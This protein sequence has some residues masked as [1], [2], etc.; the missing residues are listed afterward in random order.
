MLKLSKVRDVKTPERGTSKSAGV[1]FFIPNVFKTEVLQPGD[2]INIPS[3]IHVRVPEGY[4]FIAFNKSGVAVNKQLQ[5]GACVIDE[6]YQGEVHLHV[7]NIGMEPTT[8]R[9][10]EKLVQFILLPVSYLD[11]EVVDLEELYTAETQ[12]GTGAFGSTGLK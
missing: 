12:R 9:A 6:D 4:G 11:I 10:G 8:L 7:T 2:W 3:G 1:D 5:V